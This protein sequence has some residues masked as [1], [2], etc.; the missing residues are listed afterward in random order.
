MHKG[1]RV[2]VIVT[3]AGKGTRFGSNKLL[4][5]LAGKTVL[6]R[7]VRAVSVGIVDE[8]VV[9]VSPENE[10]EY[11]Q[12]L[13]AAELPA[14]IVTGGAERHISAQKALAAATGEIV[15]VHDGVRPF[16]TKDVI[17]NVVKNAVKHGAAMVGTPSTVQVKLVE[18]GIVMDSLDRSHSWLGQTPQGFHRRLLEGA[19]EKAEASGYARVSDDADL[20]AE[21]MGTKATIFEGHATNIKITTPQDLGTA[22]V[23]AASRWKKKKKKKSIDG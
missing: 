11:R 3:C 2:S 8:V 7:T 20:V 9:S 16:V 13:E 6:E 18:D 21:F 1:Q 4:V 14:I 12:I 15:L 17:K 22:R 23:I 5:K 19:Y 10:Q